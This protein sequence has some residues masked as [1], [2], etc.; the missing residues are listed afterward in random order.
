[1]SKFNLFI[2]SFDNNTINMSFGLSGVDS[3]SNPLPV[4][5][6]NTLWLEATR[7]L[8][9]GDLM[10]CSGDFVQACISCC[11]GKVTTSKTGK[12]T[13]QADQDTLNTFAQKFGVKACDPSCQE[14]L[15]NKTKIPPIA[16]MEG[17]TN[18][19]CQKCTMIT[20]INSIPSM[21]LTG[22][23]N[24]Y[25]NV[26][27]NTSKTC[28]SNNDCDQGVNCIKK[29]NNY[30]ASEDDLD[31]FEE[32]K[33]A[34][35]RGAYICFVIDSNFFVNIFPDTKIQ[36]DFVCYQLNDINPDNFLWFNIPPGSQMAIHSKICTVFYWGSNRASTTKY[37]F[38]I[39][40]SFNP[41]FPKSLTLEIGACIS[42]LL[43]NSVIRKIALFSY[44]FIS[45]AN[46][47][48][49]GVVD[50]KTN[51]SDWTTKWNLIKNMFLYNYP[52]FNNVSSLD[53]LKP[54]TTNVNFCG[55]TFCDTDSTSKDKYV[56]FTEKNV[57]FNLGAEGT[58]GV[59]LPEFGVKG[60]A[61]SNILPW[62]MDVMR[63]TINNAS[64]YIKFGYYGN[65]LDCNDLTGNCG[66]YEW[67][68]SDSM[69]NV[70]KNPNITTYIIQKP[71]NLPTCPDESIKNPDDKNKCQ[72]ENISEINYPLARNR[73]QNKNLYYK[74]YMK[75][76]FHWKFLMT[77]NTIFISTQHPVPF[78]YAPSGC[79]HGYDITFKNCPNIL[80]YFNNMYN[81]M[82]DNRS[83]FTKDELNRL[84]ITA[85]EFPKLSGT[86]CQLQNSSQKCCSLGINNV[87]I[88]YRDY[89]CHINYLQNKLCTPNTG[90]NCSYLN[91]DTQCGP[92]CAEIDTCLSANPNCCYDSESAKK[93]D[94]SLPWCFMKN[95]PPDTYYE[96][97]DSKCVISACDKEDKNCFKNDSNCNNSCDKKNIKPQSDDNNHTLLIAGSVIAVIIFIAIL[98]FI[99]L[100]INTKK[101]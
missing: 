11:F 33:N 71:V 55:K 30:P 94:S 66:M 75:S 59:A 50:F 95:N 96:C 12:K 46:A 52:E 53:T 29:I 54:N 4:N 9:K 78:F 100:K 42:G 57:I 88:N 86:G 99:L 31:L 23:I 65:I 26:C 15:E 91:S 6:L 70:L 2:P 92:E 19:K 81:Y 43:I 14:N 45:N 8:Q 90:V 69:K 5:N 74:F 36:T 83:Y 17:N 62:G 24:E 80:E 32:L 49:T 67:M 27:E 7:N 68:I 25:T 82:W 87:K 48:H 77:D 38:T 60:N 41:S 16:C 18:P 63:N 35:K 64:K 56:T 39:L 79:T 89:D 40:G 101:N 21:C 13:Y 1:M 85:E 76:A 37:L 98:V 61:Y 73:G 44:A 20:D 93:G 72:I 51:K 58:V 97:K 10:L 22:C 3:K 28:K 34:L 84:K 47:N